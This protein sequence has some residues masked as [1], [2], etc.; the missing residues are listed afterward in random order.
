[1]DKRTTRAILLIV[2][3]AA[4]GSI[5]L[6]AGAALFFGMGVNLSSDSQKPLPILGEVPDF[7]LTRARGGTLTR[8]DLQGKVWVASFIFTHCKAIC[9]IMT[10]G[11]N[12]VRKQLKDEP[13][14][15]EL[16][17]VSVSVDPEHDTPEV[18]RAYMQKRGL[19]DE[20][21]Y[22]L[23]ADERATTWRL[24][25]EGFKLRVGQNP[26]NPAMSINHSAKFALVDWQGRIR[27]Y[28]DG[29]LPKERQE[30]VRDIDRLF[31]TSPQQ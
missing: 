26:D 21:W 7:S 27:G 5:A 31:H 6:T 10:G 20:Q 4:V 23:T 29:T 28:Y 14:W 17:L 2:A 19:E 25:R 24:S 11:L 1:M 13:Y 18:L 16:R 9:P 12:Q 15:D 8:E 22:F 3:I 30:L